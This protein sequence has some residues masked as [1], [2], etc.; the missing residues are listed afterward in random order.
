MTSTLLSQQPVFAPPSRTVA[1]NESATVQRRGATATKPVVLNA[2]ASRTNLATQS[3]TT[4]TD[5]AARPITR[6]ATRPVAQD[7]SEALGFPPFGPAGTPAGQPARPQQPPGNFDRSDPTQ[8]SP[9]VR[10]ILEGEQPQIRSQPLPTIQVVGKVVRADGKGKALLQ[11]S[12]SYLMVTVGTPFSV[13]RGGDSTL[14][15]V[16][17]IDVESVE[18]ESRQDQLKLRLP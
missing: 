4:P 2:P 8:S 5:Q 15:T 9:D 13:P 3:N 7:G 12:G 11:V 17:N 18:L 16:T 14:F 6:V 10:R 1:Q